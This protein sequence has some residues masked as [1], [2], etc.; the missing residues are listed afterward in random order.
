KSEFWGVDAQYLDAYRATPRSPIVP[1]LMASE[2]M[3]VRMR[4][5][6]PMATLDSVFC[7]KL[8]AVAGRPYIKWR[9]IFDLWWISQSREFTRPDPQVL[10]QR[11]SFYASAYR[12]DPNAEE[13][14]A[15][16]LSDS[17]SP[18]E[19]SL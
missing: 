15:T 12:A 9:D 3:Y 4:A 10:A 8:V 6:L 7:D 17:T 1:E 14:S 5:Q 16:P 18:F 2:S 11:I 19:K 13:H